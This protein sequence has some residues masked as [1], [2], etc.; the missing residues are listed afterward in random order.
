MKKSKL[1]KKKDNSNSTYWHKK[2]MAEWSRIIRTNKHCEKCDS[3]TKLNAHHIQS[4]TI[5]GTRFK[6]ENGICLC[7]KCH[8]FGNTSAHKSIIFAEW[9]RNNKPT[10]YKWVIENYEIEENRTYKEIYKEL[11]NG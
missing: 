4:K 3:T 11:L 2:A 8:K 6:L 7:P 1:Q 5:K 10:Q 9:L